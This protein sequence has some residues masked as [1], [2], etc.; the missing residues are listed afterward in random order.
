MK[1][2]VSESF[3]SNAIA[4]KT[5]PAGDYTSSTFD[6]NSQVTQSSTLTS[7]KVWEGDVIDCVEFVYDKVGYAKGESP[8]FHGGQ[9]GALKEFHIASG[10]FLR[11]I[12]FKVGKY[13]FSADPAQ[14][15]VN[16]IVQIKFTT[17]NGNESSWYGNCCGKGADMVVSD[18]TI[19]VGK[20]NMIYAV[21]GTTQKDNMALNNYIQAL[22]AY[23]IQK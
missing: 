11:R 12:D 5:K 8:Y 1:E 2:N 18:Y 14:C 3:L 22:G 6:D 15:D 20:D 21:Y 17:H 4:G 7:I 9:N 10:D 23:Y 13:P 16:M 19:D